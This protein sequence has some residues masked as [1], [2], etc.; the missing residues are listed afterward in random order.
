V[1][2]TVAAGE[3][4]MTGAGKADV[5]GRDT[6]VQEV[7]MNNQEQLAVGLVPESRTGLCGALWS[8]APQKTTRR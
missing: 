1:D 5:R 7:Y 6:A 3:A 4:D 2:I 8:A